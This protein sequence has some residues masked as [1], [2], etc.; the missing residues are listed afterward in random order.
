MIKKAQVLIF[1]C[2]K[3]RELFGVRIEERCGEWYRTWAFKLN[4][5][6]IQKEHY[7]TKIKI[8][9]ALPEDTD[10][11]GCPY[12][13]SHGVSLC[14]CGGLSCYDGESTVTCPWCERQSEVTLAESFELNAGEL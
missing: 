3:T 12:C 14:C 1:K 7:E 4:E 11:N 6:Q 5:M 10:F 2:S 9:S 8:Q 13:G